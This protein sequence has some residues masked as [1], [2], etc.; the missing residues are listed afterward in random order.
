MEQEAINGNGWHVRVYC[1]QPSGRL[2]YDTWG[3]AHEANISTS[4]I[5]RILTQIL[6]V[7]EKWVWHRLTE[8]EKPNKKM[9]AKQLLHHYKCKR[10]L[11]EDNHHYWWN[12]DIRDFKPEVKTQSMHWEQPI[13]P[14]PKQSHQQ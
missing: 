14:C 5:F 4:S 8:D 9:T 6:K 12:T 7:A 3:T 10:E 11:I 2:P 1:Q 13:P